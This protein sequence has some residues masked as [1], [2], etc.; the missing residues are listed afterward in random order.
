MRRFM[1]MGCAAA[2][3]LAG[4]ALV[5]ERPLAAS[6]QPSAQSWSNTLPAAVERARQEG[7][8]LFLILR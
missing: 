1:V 3:I 6:P 5:V 7:K 8:P 4:L 2:G